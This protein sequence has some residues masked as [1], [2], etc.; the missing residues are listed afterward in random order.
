MAQDG[1]EL[2]TLVFHHGDV[3]QTEPHVAYIGRQVDVWEMMDINRVSV[4]QIKY[5]YEE[6]WGENQFENCKNYFWLYHGSDM[7][8]GLK[9]S[10]NDI[11]VIDEAVMEGEGNDDGD[12]GED[13]KSDGDDGD[14]GNDD[15]DDDDYERGD[16]DDD[17]NI[18]S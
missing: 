2:Y 11:D 1:F 15:S 16:G 18:E 9:S 8:D 7:N 17:A 6:H 5:L 14:D 10:K 13:D 3:L 4:S 12:D